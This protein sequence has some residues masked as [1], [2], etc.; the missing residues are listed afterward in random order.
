MA[1]FRA[2]AHARRSNR[3]HVLLDGA[4][5]I[6]D[7]RKAG[8]RLEVAV[9]SLGALRHRDRLLANLADRLA[10]LGVEVMAA[11]ASVLAAVSPVRA[12]SGAVALA[13]HRPATLK[14]AFARSGLVLAPVGVQ[15]P[16]NVGAIIRAGD[17]GAAAGVL[18]TDG[19]ADPFSWRSLRGAMG[20]TFRLPVV[21]IGDVGAAID[22]A[23]RHGATVLAAVPRG[24]SSLYDTDLTP[25]RLV[26]LGGEGSGLSREIVKAADGRI[27]IPMRRPVESLNTATAA[28]VIVYEARRQRQIRSAQDPDGDE[29]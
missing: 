9:F 8:V 22:A 28:A 17:A 3:H 6:D 26:L 12:P 4:R 1:R 7:A 10:K 27:S 23:R 14:Q 21:D 11:S 15:D 18:V 2:V 24:G 16:G 19:S 5:L 25:P 20:S 13:S 29:R